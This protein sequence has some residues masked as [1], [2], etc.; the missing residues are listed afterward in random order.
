MGQTAEDLVTSLNSRDV[1]RRLQ[2]YRALLA[3]DAVGILAIC[4]GEVMQ[5]NPSAARLFGWEPERLLGQSA[6]VFFSS[7]EEFQGFANRIGDALNAGGSPAVEWRTGAAT[8]PPS[9][10]GS[11]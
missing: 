9:G 10:R 3:N 6:A 1:Q 5:C 7:D 8:A 11:W 4:D 2:E